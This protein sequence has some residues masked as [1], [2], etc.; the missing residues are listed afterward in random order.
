MKNQNCIKWIQTWYYTT[1]CIIHNF[2][3]YIKKDDICKDIAIAEYVETKFDTWIYQ[4]YS[5]LPKRK[6]KKVIGLLKG[7]LVGKSWYNFLD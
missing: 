4:L 2:I 1:H 6:N 5:P 3:V 7:K